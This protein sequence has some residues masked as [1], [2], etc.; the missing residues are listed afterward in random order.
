MHRLGVTLSSIGLISVCACGGGEFSSQGAAGSAGAAPGGSGGSAG[1]LSGGAGGT[2]ATGGSAGQTSGGAGGTAATG[3]AG[4]TAATGGTGGT[5]AA[6][7]S[8]GQTSGGA[9]G[10]A[11]T[12]GAG[13]SGGTGGAPCAGGCPPT[14]YCNQDTQRCSECSETG[15]FLFGAPV[16]I[17]GAATSGDERFPRETDDGRQLVFKL[18]SNIVSL[19]APFTGTPT[20]RW[21]S[22]SG[23]SPRA[24]NTT[25]LHFTEA[26]DQGFAGGRRLVGV[27]GGTATPLP[28]NQLSGGGSEPLDFSPTSSD[29]RVF[30]MSNRPVGADDKRPSLLFNHQPGITVTVDPTPLTLDNG[31]APGGEDFAPWVTRDGKLLLFMSTATTSGTCTPSGT[32]RDLYWTQLSAGQ[33]V[34]SATRIKVSSPAT[35]DAEP[36]LS[37]DLCALYFSRADPAEPTRHDIYRA[38]RR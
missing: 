12:G 37:A 2:A 6:G 27:S 23:P 34:G 5:A 29:D 24:F 31:C 28:I 14:T 26:F 7:G 32:T 1:Q 15:R 4:G 17:S 13:G 21:A 20:Q 38:P 10:T 16:P 11:A 18:N 19:N 36:S 9:G 30:F 35:D 22:A 3:G 8:A 33:Q 25:E